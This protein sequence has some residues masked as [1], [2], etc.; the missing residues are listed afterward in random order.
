VPL[1]VASHE[2]RINT[3]TWYVIEAIA[4]I[5][6]ELVS[7]AGANYKKYITLA[8]KL[9]SSFYIFSTACKNLIIAVICISHLMHSAWC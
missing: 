8:R 5:V 1:F 2:H 7:S 4:N 6:K 3:R 9:Y